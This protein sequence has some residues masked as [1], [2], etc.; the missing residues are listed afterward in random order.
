[1]ED[2]ASE[3]CALLDWAAVLECSAALQYCHRDAAFFH[4]AAQKRGH[5]KIP[6]K[7]ILR[8]RFVDCARRLAIMLQHGIS[9][10]QQRDKVFV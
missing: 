5:T 6:M 1:M 2:S 3:N 7:S 8:T 9:V 4:A 10:S